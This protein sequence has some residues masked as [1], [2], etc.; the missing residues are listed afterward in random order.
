M[1]ISYIEIADHIYQYNNNFMGCM[2]ELGGNLNNQSHNNDSINS[3]NHQN[4]GNSENNNNN[5][6]QSQNQYYQQ[7]S[8]PQISRTNANSF[9]TFHSFSLKFQ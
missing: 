2:Q 4:Y 5:N 9:I 6:L 7:S 1:S 8:H 3:Q